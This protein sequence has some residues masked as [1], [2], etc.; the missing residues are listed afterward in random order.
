MHLTRV[1]YDS[2]T[3]IYRPISLA[4]PQA[5]RAQIILSVG[6]ISAS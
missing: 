1:L 2:E 3:P 4:F 5:L 6:D